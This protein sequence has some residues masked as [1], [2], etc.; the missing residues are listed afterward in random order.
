VSP[1]CESLGWVGRRRRPLT[2]SLYYN[3]FCDI[4]LNRP[5]TSGG[6]PDSP[7]RFRWPD[8]VTCGTKVRH[9]SLPVQGRSMAPVLREPPPR[10]D[11]GV[12]LSF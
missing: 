7:E 1:D 10:P 5:D 11:H 4:W 8:D 12:A 3:V 2:D 9:Q 6:S